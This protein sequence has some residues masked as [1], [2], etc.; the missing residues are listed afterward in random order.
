MSEKNQKMKFEE[1][2][3]DNNVNCS[4]YQE[5]DWIVFK[6][7]LDEKYERR[8]NWKTGETIV[9]NDDPKVQYKGFYIPEAFK[10]LN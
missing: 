4:S 2:N 6:S 3:I 10:N 1:N 7:P 9:K 8:I 5:G